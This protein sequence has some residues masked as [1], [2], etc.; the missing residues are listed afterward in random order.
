MVTVPKTLNTATCTLSDLGHIRCPLQL[1]VG[2]ELCNMADF[3]HAK[4]KKHTIITVKKK[5]K[6]TLPGV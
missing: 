1:V 5:K 2:H 6:T 4:T 3:E